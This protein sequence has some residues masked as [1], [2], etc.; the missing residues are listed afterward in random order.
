MDS[1]AGVL[2]KKGQLFFSFIV[3]RV[4]GELEMFKATTELFLAQRSGCI[5]R[6]R[7]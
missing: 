3:T 5:V 6:E 4:T 2:K 1:S 7:E